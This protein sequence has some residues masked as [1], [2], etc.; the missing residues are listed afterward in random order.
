MKRIIATAVTGLVSILAARADPPE[1]QQVPE[2][3]ARIIPPE[4]PTR[5]FVITKYGAVADGQTD[6][7]VAIAKAIDAC[8]AAGGGHVVVPAGEFFTGP[9]HLQNNVDLHLA[10]SNSVLKFSTDPKAYLPAVFTRFE[11]TECYNLSPL[12]YALDRKNIAVTGEGV[13]DGQ[14][15]DT[16]WMA[17]KHD[18]QRA[19]LVKMADANV[20]VEQRQFGEADHLRPSF[21][22]FN[23]CANI[24]IEGVR[25]RRSPMWEIHP[26]LCTN[27]TVRGVDIMS[28]GANNDGCDPE[29]CRDVLIEKCLFDTGDD[30][31]AIKSGRNNDGRRVGVPVVNLVIR[32][33]TMRDGH[34]GTAIGSEISGSCSNVFVENCD[35]SSPNL[36]YVMR[37][38]SNAVR[39]GVLQN[40][41]MRNINV[42]LVKDSVLQIDFVY[43]EGA[44]GDFPPVA[45][46]I[47][48]SNIT[49]AQTPRVLDVR[50]FP[51][52]E[53][54][55]V[56]I[57]DSTFKQIKNPDVVQNADVKLVNCSL[58]QATN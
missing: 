57:Y 4:F 44:K 8:V 25:I 56:R 50:S 9:I 16:N 24:L 40:I 51:A 58:E 13:L 12:V 55:G 10:E 36:V 32:N 39:G 42:G 18:A 52:A 54:S 6:C 46:N 53:I 7:T 38:K 35:M 15:D 22:E 30:C 20:P 45:R 33:C 28:H 21:I 14:A 29:S 3:L 47:V 5:D 26:L 48:M 31:I 11:G 27:V 23:R 37:L 41:F 1:W 34:A 17:W 43:E 2:I 19:K 49:V